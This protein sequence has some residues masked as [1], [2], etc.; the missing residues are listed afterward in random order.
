MRDD[1]DIADR[2]K[3]NG[4]TLIRGT[5]DSVDADVKKVVLLSPQNKSDIGYT[6]DSVAENRNWP[7]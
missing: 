5:R 7:I 4:Y 1:N 6:I 3:K 2:L